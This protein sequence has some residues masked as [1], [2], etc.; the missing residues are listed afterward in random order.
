MGIAED[1]VVVISSESKKCA[2]LSF[3]VGSG[4]A[5][6]GDKLYLMRS[7]VSSPDKMPQV[8]HL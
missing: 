7:P 4:I 8:L 1:I 6:D 3:S 5:L 2:D